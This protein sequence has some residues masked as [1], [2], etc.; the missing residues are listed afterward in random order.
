MQCS[1]FDLT[2]VTPGEYIIFYSDALNTLRPRQNGH[3]LAADI[4][5]YIFFSEKVWISITI[6]LN[7]VPNGPTNSM[8]ALVQ[9]MTWRLSG[10][11][12][13][14]EPMLVSLL[15]HICVTRP[16]WVK[17][18]SIGFITCRWRF[19]AFRLTS[20]FLCFYSKHPA[21]YTMWWCN[22]TPDKSYVHEK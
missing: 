17:L 22:T 13:L 6:S 19:E 8:P 3:R 14:S 18:Y 10:D 4:F 5:N 11:R 20:A 21:C 7:F 1:H 12:P 15:T 16:Q 9:I 2:K